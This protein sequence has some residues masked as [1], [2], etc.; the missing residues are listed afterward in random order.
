[1][2][3]VIPFLAVIAGPVGLGWI[4]AT[5]AAW[6][7]V[8]SAV[9]IG[10]YERDKAKRAERRA[11]SAYNASLQDRLLTIRSAVSERT[12]VLGTVRTSGTL[13]YADTV[14]LNQTALDSVIALAANRCELTGYYFG[15][16]Y[17]SAA[18]FPGN[19]Y[20]EQKEIEAHETFTVT[21]VSGSVTLAARPKD[22]TTIRGTRRLAPGRSLPINV[23]MDDVKLLRWR[24][25]DVCHRHPL[26][27]RRLHTHSRNLQER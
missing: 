20:G 7:T 25:Y 21:G 6:I 26:H 3:A 19:K 23:S 27:D 11:R 9:A 22:G 15:E 2:P 16:D 5:A 4:G 13:L 10:L 12:Y 17:V 1:M 8:G 14:G 18:N 24:E